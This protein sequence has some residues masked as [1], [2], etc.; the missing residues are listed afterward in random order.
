MEVVPTFLLV[1]I[2]LVKEAKV[3]VLG[4]GGGG[5]KTSSGFDD[6][7]EHGPKKKSRLLALSSHGELGL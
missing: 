3:E 4:A 7:F 5:E 6:F 2:T 1:H